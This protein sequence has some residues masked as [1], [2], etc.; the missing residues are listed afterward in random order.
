MTFISEL[1]D[2]HL[3][4]ANRRRHQYTISG[5]GDLSQGK[6]SSTVNRSLKMLEIKVLQERLQLVNIAIAAITD[7]TA[8]GFFNFLIFAHVDVRA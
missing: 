7:Y 6:H 3:P 1:S 5:S 2:V 4:Q 8:F